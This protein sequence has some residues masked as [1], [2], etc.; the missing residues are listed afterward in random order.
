V[1]VEDGCLGGICNYTQ[2]YTRQ[3]R[4]PTLSLNRHL[5][6]ALIGPDSDSIRKIRDL[7]ARLVIPIL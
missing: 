6:P 4:C 5:G 7:S 1:E 3:A 2:V